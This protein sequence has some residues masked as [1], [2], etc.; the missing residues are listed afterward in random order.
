MTRPDDDPRD[1]RSIL[2]LAGGGQ[3]GGPPAHG[4]GGG[5]S[6][7]QRAV[8]RLLRDRGIGRHAL[9]LTQR[10]G[11]ALPDGL[12]SLSG[13]VLDASSRV[14]GFWL[15][16]DEAA[17]ALTLAPFYLVENAAHAFADDAEYH[18]ARRALGLP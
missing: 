6:P 2:P 8:A 10:E 17:Q 5:L 18:A 4:R 14:H 12:E 13:F 3:G 7:E 1:P 9:F 15:T 16:W 11:A